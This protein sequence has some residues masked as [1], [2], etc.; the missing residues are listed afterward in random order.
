MSQI[1]ASA[2][3]ILVSYLK[4][5]VS[6]KDWHGVADAAMDI[7]ELVARSPEVESAELPTNVSHVHYCPNSLRFCDFVC[8][9]CSC[10]F[11]TFHPE[12]LQRT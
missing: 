2:Y 9:G 1:A 6:E 4:L 3:S 10:N 7:R 5:K 8:V 12:L 11:G